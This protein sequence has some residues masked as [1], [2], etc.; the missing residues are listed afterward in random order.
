MTQTVPI[1]DRNRGF[2]Q[3]HMKEIYTGPQGTGHHV[4][5]KDDLVFSPIDGFYLVTEVDY[6]T[7][8]TE[9]DRWSMPD[10]SG[11]DASQ[12]LWESLGPNQ[13][14]ESFRVYLDTSVMPHTLAF[15]SRLLIPGSAPTMIKVF[16]GTRLESAPVVSRQ[17][18]NQGQLLGENIPLELVDGPNG[19]NP[20]MKRP[21]VGHCSESLHD[22]EVVTVVAYDSAG[23]V[24]SRQRMLV[25]NTQWIRPLNAS[26]KYVTAIELDS[27]FLSSADSRTLECPI[28][29]PIEMIARRGVV[30]YSDGQKRTLDIDGG[31][32]KLFG[33]RRFISTVLGQKQ[34]MTLV[35]N[36]SEDEVAYGSVNGDTMHLTEDYLATTVKAE[37]AYSVKLF[38]YP[39]W[40][41]AI[42]GYRLEH[43]L[44][45][46]DREEV[47][48]VTGLVTLAAN[49][50]A[51]QPLAYGMA[52]DLT[53][54]INLSQV[55]N[56]FKNYNHL[57]TTRIS[58][59]RPGTD[60][61]ATRWTVTYD[62]TKPSYGQDL[63]AEVEFGNGT[64]WTLRIDNGKGSREHWLRDLYERAL[65]LFDQT[66][67][68]A[69]PVPNRMRIIAGEWEA[70]YTVAMWNE[71]ITI[72]QPL[73]NGETVFI[74]F[75]RRDSQ[76][77][78]ELAT[79]GLAVS[80]VQSQG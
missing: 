1:M 14:L 54:R 77:D 59:L 57:Q 48:R 28:N 44:Y 78:L 13:G 46:L 8:L 42:N 72:D 10:D 52:Q 79:I 51:F 56:R 3:W 50:T 76:T 75:L 71:A 20:A 74:Q 2:R 26:A 21:V 41:D 34:P 49:S 9:L 12:G 37:G 19:P 61:T 6:T 5:N 24:Y 58:L 68:A 27:P 73:T 66:A 33:L 47:H 11:E 80:E 43:F 65:P 30:Y 38:S 32:F 45:N 62:K 25:E 31:K 36:L 29:V 63:K 40:I 22:M 70:E 16:R 53:F 64:L 23:T 69:P 4:P 35:Y 18:D 60:H 17:Y 67:E 15:D 39:V 55:S 7:G